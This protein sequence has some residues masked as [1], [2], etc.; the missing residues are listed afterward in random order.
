MLDQLI[1]Q[2]YTILVA[3]N[4]VGRDTSEGQRLLC[5]LRA[6][7]ALNEGISEYEAQERAEYEAMELKIRAGAIR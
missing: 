3:S 6:Q 7:V 1:R 2:T 5:Q 4:F